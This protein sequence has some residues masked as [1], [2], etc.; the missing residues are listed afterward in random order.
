MK[1]KD[2]SHKQTPLYYLPLKPQCMKTTYP[3]TSTHSPHRTVL[4]YESSIW[5]INT[6]CEKRNTTLLELALLEKPMLSP[7][8]VS[9][10]NIDIY[11]N[12]VIHIFYMQMRV[13]ASSLKIVRM[14]NLAVCFTFAKQDLSTETIN[15]TLI[16]VM[17]TPE[18]L[19]ASTGL[20][21][22]KF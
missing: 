6:L 17:T 13:W 18:L 21:L 12:R 19:A 1:E 4:K 2:Q 8:C 14:L 15:N 20:F 3:L 9:F 22:S 16:I 7:F 11:F 10:Q 5:N